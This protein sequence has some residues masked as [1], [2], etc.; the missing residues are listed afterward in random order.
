MR[1]FQNVLSRALV[2]GLGETSTLSE[3]TVKRRDTEVV[4]LQLFSG[5]QGI[6]DAY[7]LEESFDMVFAAKVPD[8][9][10]DWAP[11][12]VMSSTFV[13]DEE[14]VLYRAKPSFN[15]D[16]L[17]RMFLGATDLINVSTGRDLAVTDK[18]KLLVVT[19]TGDTTVTI[20][21]ALE[22]GSVVG[23]KVFVCA[24]AAD[25]E[26]ALTIA[27]AG[28]ITINRDTKL[29]LSAN[30]LLSGR[31]VQLRKT[32]ANTW[33]MEPA[34]ELASIS[35]NAEFSYRNLSEPLGWRSTDKFTLI[36]END[37]I[38]GNE[39]APVTL[40]AAALYVTR[41]EL[42]GGYLTT[43]QSNARYT[44]YDAVQSLTTDQRKTAR[45]NIGIVL[46]P[47]TLTDGATINWDLALGVNAV[48]T[49]AGNRT[50]AAPTNGISGMSGHLMVIQD[51]TGSRTL[52]LNSAWTKEFIGNTLL[53]P[54]GSVT[55]LRWYYDGTKYRLSRDA[56]S[57]DDQ[58]VQLSGFSEAQVLALQNSFAIPRVRQSVY[59]DR[60]SSGTA[61]LVLA[62]LQIPSTVLG[63]EVLIEFECWGTVS[64]TTTA[65]NLTLWVKVGGTKYFSVAHAL[66]TTTNAGREFRAHGFLGISDLTL[67]ALVFK[68]SL[69]T[70]FSTTNNLSANY[71][72]TS[73]VDG[74]SGVTIQIGADVSAASSSIFNARGH[75][76]YTQ[77]Y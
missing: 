57:K 45:E 5:S 66:G 1:F 19:S 71:G 29:G 76:K 26:S 11:S 6:A 64:N 3:A 14:L 48:V 44:R 52:T 24:I 59:L 23:D 4:E 27:A 51:A 28:S 31:Y 46:A 39:G 50:L 34:V 8:D 56:Q 32:A 18:S 61:D 63:S 49:L 77:L 42:L 60:T 41:A 70:R 9:W 62:S 36:I 2:T 13:F 15:T 74:T 43:T 22:A 65:S 37:I 35:L 17:L 69:D 53:E 21:A 16:Q 55:V 68:G 73:A 38:R 33:S 75:G 12:V 40:D 7:Q 47:Q 67:A 30:E 25:T 58:V 10:S 72:A 54:A 20:S